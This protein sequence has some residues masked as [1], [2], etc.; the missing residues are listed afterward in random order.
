MAPP[1]SPGWRQRREQVHSAF[2]HA[3]DAADEIADKYCTSPPSRGRQPEA[4]L[5][6]FDGRASGSPR[7]LSAGRV[8][9]ATPRHRVTARTPLSGST[10]QRARLPQSAHTPQSTRTPAWPAS[11]A[12]SPAKL[13]DPPVAADHPAEEK[14]L[15][16]KQTLETQHDFGRVYSYK[17]RY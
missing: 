5:N 11:A 13:P 16:R 12:A 1:S 3:A 4:K 7:P 8:V 9:Q 17:P 14:R 15:R 6:V 2:K 10:L